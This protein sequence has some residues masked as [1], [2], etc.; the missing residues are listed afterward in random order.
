MRHARCTC[1]QLQLQVRGEPTRVSICHCRACQRRTGSIYGVQA[2][3]PISAVRVDGR[4]ARYLRTA[5]NG[6][7]IVHHFCPD[8]G[9]TVYF[10][11]EALPDDYVIAVGTF[12][13]ADFPAPS[14]SVYE[15][16]QHRWAQFALDLE[17]YD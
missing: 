13:D 9:S 11:R 8:C 15:A 5:D 6:Q 7:R 3:F 16:R 10:Q 17:H 14:L 12:A 1:G 2:R 4:S